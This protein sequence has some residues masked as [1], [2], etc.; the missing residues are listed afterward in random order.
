MP[1]KLYR[2]I[3]PKDAL[4]AVEP[5]IQRQLAQSGLLGGGSSVTNVAGEPADLTLS[6]DY[7]GKYAEKLGTE[8]R[9]LLNSDL[10]LPLYDQ[11]NETLSEAGYYAT[12]RGAS[13]RVNPRSDRLATFD[14]DLVQ[15]DTRASAWRAVE[16]KPTQPSPGNDFGGN[17]TTALVGVP[18]SATKVR[19]Y[20]AETHEVADATVQATR[21]AEFGDVD[22]VDAQDAPFGDPT[23]IYDLAYEHAGDVDVGV[24]D[25]YGRAKRDSDGVVAWQRVFDPSHDYRGASVVDTGLLRVTADEDAQ[26]LT[27]E[28]WDSG[29]EEWTA[30]TLG[31]SDWALFD[32]DV[33]S[34][35][36]AEV[37]VLAEFRDS[38]TSEYYSLE[39]VV[40]RGSE[41]IQWLRTENESEPV[42]SGLQDLLDPIASESVV[43]PTAS[44]AL[45]A[46]TEVR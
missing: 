24:W 15:A 6:G 30:L 43:V 42:P 8:L 44:S 28:A 39:G 9:E 11:G 31:V 27:A 38:T 10:Q 16:T 45:V 41:A 29:T 22:M 14:A 46:R 40:T 36:M 2:T 13:A 3:L 17:D 18:S 33:R 26:S 34:I 5:S 21:S 12:Q 32:W 25:S 20:N 1:L 37:R 19:W 4:Q 35:G 23:L 7:R